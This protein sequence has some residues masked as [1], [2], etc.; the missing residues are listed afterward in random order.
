MQISSPTTPRQTQSGILDKLTNLGFGEYPL[1]D[2]MQW[3][4]H[5]L[6]MQEVGPRMAAT[7]VAAVIVGL[8]F[9][10]SASTATLAIW[11]GMNLFVG[12]NSWLILGRYHNHQKGH[13]PDPSIPKQRRA[14][15][16]WHLANLYLSLLWGFQWATLPLLFLGD[17]SIVQIFSILLLVTI[18]STMPSISMGL[19]PDIYVAFLTPVL[20]AFGWHLWSMDLEDVWLHKAMAP[21]VWLSL[22]GFSYAMFKTQIHALATRLELQHSKR[23]IELANQAKTRFLVAA[24]HDIRQPLQA[25]SLYWSAIPDSAVANAQHPMFERLGA[26]LKATNELLNHLLDVSRLDAGVATC[27]P[28]AIDLVE[29]LGEL[30]VVFSPLAERKGLLLEIDQPP[31]IYVWCDRA[32]TLQI[33]KNLLA[34]AIQYTTTGAVCISIKNH[35]THLQ[36]SVD[37]TGIG[38]PKSHQQAIFEEFVQLHNPGRQHTKG[39][40]LGLA[41][42]RRLCQLQQLPLMLESEPGHGSCF[43]ITLPQCKAPTL[44]Q[45]PYTPA[46]EARLAGLKVLVVDDHEDIVEALSMLLVS[47]DCDVWVAQGLSSLKQQLAQPACVPEVVLTDDM[48]GDDG[49]AEDVIQ[50]VNRILESIPRIV[51]MTGNTLPQRMQQL[52]SLGLPMLHKPVQ[53][54]ELKALLLQPEHTPAATHTETA[55]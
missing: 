1:A 31:D 30:R 32:M 16:R 21:A 11:F 52:Q 54:E 2:E 49:Q 7:L 22:V 9:V 48:L 46:A 36:I 35:S 37:D 51:I 33:F 20:T 43:H 53:G 39:L 29:L 17:A 42:V 23:E 24:S 26:S 6:F 19:Y 5:H 4:R 45:A 12:L 40:G 25:A 14:I 34:N 8:L 13:R 18:T 28:A 47:W 15:L 44:P 41:I 3:E 38:I 55:I 10:N 27:Q 50:V